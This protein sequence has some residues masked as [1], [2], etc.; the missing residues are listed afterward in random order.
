MDMEN[1]K[2]ENSFNTESSPKPKSK[3]LK[4]VKIAIWFIVGIAAIFAVSV[5]IMGPI[6]TYLDRN[7]FST[8]PANQQQLEYV[9]KDEYFAGAKNDPVF[10][11]KLEE[12]KADGVITEWEITDLSVELTKYKRKVIHEEMTQINKRLVDKNL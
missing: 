1:I 9:Y 7:Y 2:I 12:Y 4:L 5:L 11:K 10:K 6:N 8:Y 3:T